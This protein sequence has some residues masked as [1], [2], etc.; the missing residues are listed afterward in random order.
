MPDLLCV[1]SL[2]SCGSRP[3]ILLGAATP[4]EQIW[5]LLSAPLLQGCCSPFS[6]SLVPVAWF[7]VSE[8]LHQAFSTAL[9]L[10]WRA[11]NDILI[12]DGTT[13]GC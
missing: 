5:P 11:C 10:D 8:A 4:I 2:I 6:S 12:P 9:I 13:S 3:S 1:V 7:E